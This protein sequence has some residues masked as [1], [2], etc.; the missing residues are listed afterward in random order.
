MPVT[1]SHVLPFP[2]PL[3][4]PVLFPLSHAQEIHPEA[5]SDKKLS[6]VPVRL[7]A[8]A[9]VVPLFPL[10]YSP[11]V[12][13]HSVPLSRLCFFF[14]P[15]PISHAA[16]IL[17]FRR[18]LKNPKVQDEAPKPPP[19]SGYLLFLQEVRPSMPE[20]MP[21]SES[22]AQPCPSRSSSLPPTLTLSFTFSQL[23]P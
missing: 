14:L 23:K 2:A 13:H 19:R 21:F 4:R 5:K 22:Q 10:V 12:Y 16:A 9:A 3:K 7:A 15:R 20:E 17:L 11:I 8:T 1:K 18:Q 6:R